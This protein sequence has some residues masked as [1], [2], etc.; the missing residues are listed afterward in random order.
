[1]LVKIAAT[2][3]AIA[4]VLSST[5]GAAASG[6]SQWI[7][8][9]SWAESQLVKKFPGTTPLCAPVGPPSRERGFNGYSEFACVVTLSARSSYVF[10]IKPRSKAA[11]TT[12][13]IEKPS[14]QAAGT[15]TG[16]TSGAVIGSSQPLASKTLDGSRLS[17]ADG[18]S[19]LVSPAGE[20]ATV[21]WRSNDQ[22]TVLQG[23]TPGYG[24]QLVDTSAGSAAPARLLRR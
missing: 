22:I 1:V 2:Y 3:F 8:P 10:V 24:Y 19:W 5:G 20:Y 11:W 14:P 13:R 18:S 6:P 12:L 7:W 4:L 17:L 21:L 9:K 23:A 15:R 16:H